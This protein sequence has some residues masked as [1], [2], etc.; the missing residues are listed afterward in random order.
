M[1]KETRVAI[2]LGYVGGMGTALW[3]RNSHEIDPNHDSVLYSVLQ[4]RTSTQKP[5][6]DWP[7]DSRDLGPQWFPTTLRT[8]P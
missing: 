8:H 2:V 3:P 4:G 6:T 5:L 1:G 7:G